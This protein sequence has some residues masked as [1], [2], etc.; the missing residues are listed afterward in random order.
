MPLRVHWITRLF[1]M[2]PSTELVFNL[3]HR[4]NMNI[5]A[6]LVSNLCPTLDGGR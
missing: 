1:P 2:Q 6:A 5:N 3:K 4:L